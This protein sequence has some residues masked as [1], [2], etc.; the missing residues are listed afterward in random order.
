MKHQINATFIPTFVSTVHHCHQHQEMRFA[1][2]QVPRSSPSAALTAPL[3]CR[4]VD[5]RVKLVLIKFT[6]ATFHT[7]LRVVVDL[8][9]VKLVITIYTSASFHTILMEGWLY[10]IG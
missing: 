4:Q 2:P 6:S 10:Q 1:S 7:I 5:T 9:V 8:R 3:S